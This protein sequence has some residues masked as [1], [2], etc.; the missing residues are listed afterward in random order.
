MS[1]K[2]LSDQSLE[3]EPVK[4]EKG[5]SIKGPDGMTFNIK[6]GATALMMLFNNKKDKDPDG[7]IGEPPGNGKD[8]ELK[9][10]PQIQFDNDFAWLKYRL[11]G[12][13]K[14]SP[15]GK[16]LVFNW[17]AGAEKSAAFNWYRRHDKDDTV[18]AAIRDDLSHFRFVVRKNDILSLKKKE[19]LSMHVLGRLDGKIS[20]KWSDILTGILGKLS[21]NI[22]ASNFASV[23]VEDSLEGT[24]KWKI[25]DAFDIVF[26]KTENGEYRVAVKKS[27]CKTLGTNIGFGIAV[28]LDSKLDD[29][30]KEV[31]E[32]VIGI[33]LS[34]LEG[35]LEGLDLE[36]I[37]E[38]LDRGELGEDKKKLVVEVMNRL[39]LNWHSDKLKTLKKEI[40]RIK[41][42][43]LP[44]NFLEV[45]DQQITAKL[46]Y[47]Y[48]RI[49]EKTTIFQAILSEKAVKKYH[50]FLIKQE[51]NGLLD[52][53]KTNGPD[54]GVRLEK[55]I[56]Q[57]SVTTREAWGFSLGFGKWTFGGK[58]VKELK[59]VTRFSMDERPKKSYL[60][61]RRYQDMLGERVIN[62]SVDF[63][64]QMKD[65]ARE[66]QARA[67][68]FDYSFFL[69]WEWKWKDLDDILDNLL[70][71]VD[72]AGVW[73]VVEPDYGV[74]DKEVAL[75]LNKQL[76]DKSDLEVTC[77]L[78]FDPEAF[79]KLLPHLTQRNEAKFAQA[80]A[81]ALPYWSGHH[82]SRSYD[83][84]Q[85]VYTSLWE[86]YFIEIR[87]NP[88]LIHDRYTRAKTMA[89]KAWRAI[90]MKSF[91]KK[92][93]L[94]HRE[95]VFWEKL[96][97]STF[98]GLVELNEVNSLWDQFIG[99]MNDLFEAIKSN[100]ID[101][102][103]KASWEKANEFWS[104]A[105]F[106]RTF[107]AYLLKLAEDIPGIWQY[108]ERILRVDY[109][110]KTGGK[111]KRSLIITKTV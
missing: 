50:G 105:F 12:G 17:K 83:S 13:V 16:F 28:K 38:E 54:S 87:K 36:K 64:A 62:F 35:I 99:A 91:P 1:D 79:R 88:H 104:V 4:F 78:K 101:T 103:I 37:L 49:K 5:A 31:E 58:E 51:L 84:R 68:E 106:V 24:F 15:E 89:E 60:G 41:K 11:E 92:G 29:I 40:N 47:E 56:N 2:K 44:H 57:T 14:G 30:L 63:N 21:F 77:H 96:K 111:K 6:A 9:L 90:R 93:S 81:M 23:D 34:K 27:D 85:I 97:T 71:I 8:E 108:I 100:G 22:L 80:L 98:A 61:S 94:A 109:R 45:L 39:G 52:D 67:S 82:V 59:E 43:F 19:A 65:F 102:V 48:S 3:V 107:G 110:E 76:K 66:K 25:K 70:M 55:L 75:E 32:G 42:E 86:D 69:L 72:H 33:P 74:D 10:D 53:I 7:I 46:T 18:G 73:K 20:M 26:S 95:G